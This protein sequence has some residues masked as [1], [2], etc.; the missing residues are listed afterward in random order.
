MTLSSVGSMPTFDLLRSPWL[1]MRLRDGASV[2]V[3]LHECLTHPARF[4][5]LDVTQPTE[6]IALYRLLLAISH[7][8]IGPGT[9]DDRADLLANWPT[10]AIE[11][12]LSRWASRFDL[13]GEMPF[14]QVK[15]LQTTDLDASPW[16]RLALDRSSG[17]ARLLWD[18]SVDETVVPI[19]AAV[20]ARLLVGHLQFTPGGLVRAFRSS[21]TRG[22]AC[23]LMCV[24][25]I[26]D[27]LGETLALNLI[28]QSSD[29]YVAD[30]PPWEVSEPDLDSFRKGTTAVLAGP[31]QRYTHLSRALLLRPDSQGNVSCVIYAEGFD[32]AASPRLDPMA[33]GRRVDGEIRSILMNGD[34]VFWRDLHALV[35]EDG[36]AP[37]AC[38]E[39]ATVLRMQR[40]DFRPLDLMAGGLLTDKAKLVL[41]R[42]EERRLSPRLLASGSANAARIRPALELAEDAGSKLQAAFWML[43]MQWLRGAGERDP[44]R[45]DMA[46]V[47]DQLNGMPRYWSML[48]QGFWQFIDRLSENKD[49]DAAFDLWTKDVRAALAGAWNTTAA[50]LGS[51]G[52]A[53]RAISLASPRLAHAL[54]IT[55]PAPAEA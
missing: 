48:E 3:G 53:L 40:G 44:A 22:A 2:V 19:E 25:V 14:L 20:A 5:G 45:A 18:H 43:A 54:S 35:A 32:V 37:P 12:Y 6:V 26:G 17:N 7:R 55:K 50:Q 38:V 33:A 13:F 36:N 15:A 51:G 46:A 27:H 16:T 30:T 11:T 42:V 23:G 34:R 49:P 10:A 9:L 29:E 31:A 4:A 39:T 8:A 47:L 41:W 21:G 24:L 28:A 52:R 1:P